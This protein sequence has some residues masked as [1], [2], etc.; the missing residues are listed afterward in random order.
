MYR[1][2]QFTTLLFAALVLFASSSAFAY[3][4]RTTSGGTPLRWPAG[5]V[6]VVVALDRGPANVNVLD[7]QAAAVMAFSMYTDTLHT[8]APDVVLSL[9]MT[10]DRMTEGNDGKNV[11]RW[12]MHDWAEYYDPGALAVTLTSYDSYTGRITDADI[13]VNAA[14][15]PWEASSDPA[16]CTN[17][18]DLQNV[19][20]H[21]VGHVLG[22]GH[23]QGDTDATMYPSSGMCETK[24][25]DLD[26]DDDAGLARLY[27]DTV[28]PSPTDGAAALGCAVGG[29]GKDGMMIVILVAGAMLLGN[30]RPRALVALALALTLGGLSAS[31]A[32]AT[33]VRRLSLDEMSA[34][35]IVVVRA[36]VGGVAAQRIGGHIYTDATLAI[37]ECLKG[38]CGATMTVRQLGG[39][40][41]GYGVRVEG[42]AE[43]TPGTEVV[44]LLRRRLDGAYA[45]L[46]MAQG[47][48]RVEREPRRGEITTLVHG[49]TAL[50]L[51]A[52]DGTQSP[53]SLERVTLDDIR[54]SIARTAPHNR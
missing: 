52:P 45:P 29:N 30:R 31:P 2:V 14:E 51:A 50:R 49:A 46:G 47:A 42:S 12:V 1:S 4:V 27:V 26:A 5:T 6:D 13:V 15:Y 34:D 53:A 38:S 10:D 22:L 16:A 11:V 8:M 54:A 18:Y 17:A 3:K 41:D 37:S 35:A 28:A 19:L 43:L 25:R 36:V 23:E 33:T 7:A 9:A 24:K 40:L 44:L 39:E 20:T 32:G 48:F 21:E